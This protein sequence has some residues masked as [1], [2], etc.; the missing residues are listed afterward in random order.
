MAGIQWTYSIPVL[1]LLLT[2]WL[3][4]SGPI[5]SLGPTVASYDMAGIQWTCPI[6]VLQLLLTI[7]LA[8]SEPILSL[9]YS[10]FL[11]YGWHTVDLAVLSLDPTVAS[12]DMAGIQ[13]TYSIFFFIL[14]FI[15]V[16]HS[17]KGRFSMATS[18][19]SRYNKTFIF[20]WEE[21]K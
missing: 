2:I 11:R 13:W 5:L 16:V 14:L 12:D 19:T 10:C 15:L 17:A 9:S 18:D 8:Y 1:Q 4:Y 20:A 6:P 21:V 7:W 3:A